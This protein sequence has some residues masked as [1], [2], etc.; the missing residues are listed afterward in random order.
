MRCVGR[1]QATVHLASV[2]RLSL[3]AGAYTSRPEV[4]ASRKGQFAST[5]GEAIKLVAPPQRLKVET[6]P[7][8]RWGNTAGVCELVLMTGFSFVSD[9]LVC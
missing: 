9:P 8:G 2:Y 7:W 5:R 3:W 6:S 4:Q 1:H